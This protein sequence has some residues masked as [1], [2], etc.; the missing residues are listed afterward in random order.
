M[1][2][3]SIIHKNKIYTFFT[4]DLSRNKLHLKLKEYLPKYMLP[5]KIIVIKKL[6]ENINQKVDEKKLIKLI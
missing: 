2:S 3:H 5:S 1:I 4:G 6:P